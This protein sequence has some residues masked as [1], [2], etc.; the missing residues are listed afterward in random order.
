[1]T[2]TN[3][4]GATDLTTDALKGLAGELEVEAR[5]PRHGDG[6]AVLFWNARSAV[7]ALIDRREADGWRD[8]STAPRDGTPILTYSGGCVETEA[9]MVMWWS[10][11][12]AEHCGFGWEAY[13]VSHMLAPTHWQPLPEP[14]TTEGASHERE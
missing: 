4:G 11:D 9:Q 1:M 14:P 10:M 7:L 2:Q 3:D 13:E 8:I 6:L 5:H 12:K